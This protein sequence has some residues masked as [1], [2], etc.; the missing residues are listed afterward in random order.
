MHSQCNGIEAQAKSIKAQHA[1]GV[2][3]EKNTVA[4]IFCNVCQA[5]TNNAIPV[6]A[7]SFG[8]AFDLRNTPPN[9]M[10]TPQIAES[11]IAF[12]ICICQPSP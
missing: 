4:K 2:D 1:I 11:I 5:R 8:A 10:I 9:I 7:K 12:I 3:I 6:I